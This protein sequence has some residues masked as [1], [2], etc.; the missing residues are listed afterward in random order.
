MARH[1]NYDLTKK[2]IEIYSAICDCG[3]T[4]TAELMENFKLSK[5]TI[6]THISSIFQKLLVSSIAELI[7][8]H[9]RGG[10]NE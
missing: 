6:R 4:H 3:M 5:S 10:T 2:E 8:R 7:Y 1:K 9:Y